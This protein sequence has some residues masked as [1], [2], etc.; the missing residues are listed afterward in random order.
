MNKVG[1]TDKIIGM[2]IAIDMP[3]RHSS[4]AKVVN[5]QIDFIVIVLEALVDVWRLDKVAHIAHILQM[6]RMY[7]HCDAARRGAETTERDATEVAF[8]R[9]RGTLRTQIF[10][11]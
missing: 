11:T 6:L 9:G 7:S 4:C 1:P 2:Y 5:H 8:R 3:R 10:T